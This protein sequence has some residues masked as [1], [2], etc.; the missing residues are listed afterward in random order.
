[1][2]SKWGVRKKSGRI[3]VEREEVL[4]GFPYYNV[5]SGEL[6]CEDG[7]AVLVRKGFLLM[8]KSQICQN[9]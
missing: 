4:R 2:V 1:M 9:S 6:L 5:S 7:S 3:Y 8:L